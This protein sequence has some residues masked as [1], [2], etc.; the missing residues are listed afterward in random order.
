MT[1]R[2]WETVLWNLTRGTC[3]LFLGPNLLADDEAG[4]PS[5]GTA[6]ALARHLAEQ[7]GDTEVGDLAQVAQRYVSAPSFGRNDLEREVVRFYGRANELDS[8]LH[9][10]LA[11]LPFSLVV[12]SSHDSW[13]Q[14]AF[15]GEGK[16]PLVGFYNY[17]GAKRDCPQ[18]GSLDTPLV[19][20]LYGCTNEPRSLVITEN[21]LL[22]FL[23]AVVAK[24]PPLPAPIVSEFQKKDI[25]FLFL[26]FGIRHWYLRILLHV[27][28][29]NT[30]VRSF[31]FEPLRFDPKQVQQTVLF[32]RKGYKIEVVDSDVASFVAELRRR[33]EDATDDPGVPV[34]RP[35]V[36]RV[37]MSY[38]SEDR[39][40]ASTVREALRAAGFDVWFDRDS[41][42]PGDQW[43]STIESALGESD[44]FVVLNSRS[45]QQKP[46]SYVNKEINLAFERQRLARRGIRYIFPALVDDAPLLPE[47]SGLQAVSLSNADGLKQLVSS[48]NRDV[49]R[50]ARV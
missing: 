34:A 25:S 49:Q 10:D 50:R 4:E 47:L 15:S 46:F 11:A 48:I 21:D 5:E 42:E 27:L 31:A 22:D 36:A 28:K 18:L 3:V 40:K 9:R 20:H 29:L 33:F 12:S 19:Y 24:D 30:E 44:Y 23:V 8:D 38:A 26:G 1:E 41:L 39:E 16:T 43:D 17:R 6:A 37:F 13:M 2:D 32:Y 45:L 14:N 35:Q 7:T